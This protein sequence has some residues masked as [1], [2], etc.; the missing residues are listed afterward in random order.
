MKIFITM[1]LLCGDPTNWKLKLRLSIIL[2]LVSL[3]H[4]EASTYSQNT[5]ITLDMESVPV[6][7][8]LKMIESQSEFK[9][10]CNVNEID[11]DRIVTVKA[12][13]QR[14]TKILKILFIDT[15]TI[16]NVVD[17]QIILTN[18]LHKNNEDKSLVQLNVVPVQEEIELEG[19]VTDSD[20]IL[21]PDV[22]VVIKG[23][24]FGTSTDF[25]GN[26]KISVP[27][28][29]SI[30]VISY[31]GMED[32]EIVVGNQT[33][34]N[35]VMVSSGV[36]LDDVVITALGMKREKKALGYSVG[37]VKSKD[38]TIVPQENAVNA[39]TAKV[40]GLQIYNTSG[41]INS[42]THIQIRGRTSLANNDRPLI[43]IDGVPAGNDSGIL[44]DM[45]ANTIASVSVLKG[46]S[47]AALYGS[48]AGNGVVIVTTK[49]GDA[50]QRGIGVS[51]DSSIAII[52]PYKFVE[53]QDRF[54]SGKG[55][56]FNESNNQHWFGPE[57]GTS[58]IQ[59][60]SN[61]ESV[62]LVF[63]ED[64][65]NKFFNTGHTFNN[66][67]SFA[68]NYE[69]G[70]FR[71]SLGDIR[72]K[73]TLPGAELIKNTLDVSAMY[74]I[75]EK[76][77]VSTNV[78]I[79]NSHSDNF[80]IQKHDDYPYRDIQFIPPHVN[81]DDLRPVWVEGL[82]DVQQ[83]TIDQGYD[84]AFFTA[85]ESIYKFNKERVNANVKLDYEFS[86]GFT[87][88][89]RVGR[90]STYLQNDHEVGYSARRARQGLYEYDNS[91]NVETNL[92]ILISYDNKFGNF[93]L[94]ASVGGNS[95]YQKAT[96]TFTGG[97]NLIVPGLFTVTNVDRGGIK[98]ETGHF[99]KRVYSIYGL[100][101]VS[102]KDFV[103]LDLT[104]RNDWSSTLPEENRSYFYPSVSFSI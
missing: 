74:K 45:N 36:E 5:K 14:I 80:R 97:N 103:Y 22:N 18:D 34:F 102:Y 51:F 104:A 62:P 6:E 98:Y 35:I 23:T 50:G 13:K 26:F 75:T 83:I 85:Y 88:F 89:G 44:S 1:G 12:N 3:F 29:S 101:S 86:D 46:P 70:N 84:N 49:S 55:G 79:A 11:I 42:E 4:M 2:L 32:Q 15:N 10:F 99:E 90:T 64:T 71:V 40:S 21:L 76:F 41:D 96:T 63:Y 37:E 81:I 60:N 43:V 52:D 53:L 27:N 28:T 82:E 54:T 56:I 77:K 68:G 93:G 91:L 72:S 59:W 87:V 38:L 16:Y 94:N 33:V 9:F 25:D 19:S 100:A 58:A 61:G 73:G 47:A 95:L 8:V 69:K 48:R 57:E 31:L 39:L 66:S 24:T 65:P 67:L 30:L 17:R 78:L 20:G 92:D 7:S